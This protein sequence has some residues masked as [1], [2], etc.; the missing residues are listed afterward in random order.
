MKSFE[1]LD[2][3]AYLNSLTKKDIINSLTTEDV[4]SFLES[5]GA[6][7]ERNARGLV[8]TTICHNPIEEAES[9][10][11]YYY[12]DRKIF[13]CYTE[14]GESMSIFELYKRYMSLNH[15]DIT[16]EEAEDFL[17][18]FL[19]NKV[20]VITQPKKK[21][22]VNKE[23]YL[24]ERQILQDPS[25]SK[26][27][28][29]CFTK[30]YHPSWLAEGITKEVMDRFQ[31]RFSVH[32]N[33]IVIPHFDIDGR[34]IGIRGRAL[35]DYDLQFGKYMPITVGD[36]MYSH[37]LGWN[38]YGIYEHKKAIQKYHRAIIYESEKSVMLDEVY[39]GEN[40]CAVAVCGSVLNKNQIGL[41]KKLGA[42]EIILAFDK[43]YEDC[44]S[45]KGKKYRS[46]IV[47]MGKK[48]A[49][50]A[51]FFYLFD[52][53]NL[54]NEKDS[55]IDRGLEIFQQLYQKRIKIR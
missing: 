52:E 4:K 55:P 41:L 42:T 9:M 19:K 6:P 44:Y 30:Y 45:E 29:D 47:N 15:S 53:K 17:K 21:E 13:H 31:I 24:F 23:R 10:K 37:H 48:Y 39:Y 54:L 33:K 2:E 26:H 34:L 16:D 7:V 3:V 51:S 49:H 35:D 43:E 20:V 18:K 22:L 11:L 14:C 46:K 12:E 5:L 32:Q 50:C 25:Y 40:S 28:L 38:L 27:I 8:T 36:E 1:T